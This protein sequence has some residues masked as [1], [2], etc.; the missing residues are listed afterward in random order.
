MFYVLI[1]LFIFVIFL[2]FIY[3]ALVLYT[4]D[5]LGLLQKFNCPFCMVI[6]FFFFFFFFFF[7]RDEFMVDTQV[8]LMLTILKLRYCLK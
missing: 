5:R 6:D 4:Q 3:S 2:L 8:S 7:T 1:G